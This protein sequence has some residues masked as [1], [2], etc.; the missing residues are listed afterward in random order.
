MTLTGWQTTRRQAAALRRAIALAG[1]EQKLAALAGFS[2][3]AINKAKRRGGVSA[4]MAVA[5]ERATA[6]RVARAELR[7][8]LFGAE[9]VQD[10]GRSSR[11]GARKATPELSGDEDGTAI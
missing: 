5:I 4:E 8:D 3:V 2:Q 10:H 9:T 1:S 11:R 7:A 6:G